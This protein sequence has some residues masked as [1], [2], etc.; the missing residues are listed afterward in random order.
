MQATLLRGVFPMLPTPFY[1]DGA[2]ALDDV[3]RLVDFAL[4]QGSAGVAALGLGGEA[5]FL[6]PEERKEVAREVLRAVAGR[7][8]VIVGCTAEDTATACALAAHAAGHGAAVVMV[9]PPNRAGISS[10]E[11]EAHY[12]QVALAAQPAALMVQDAPSFLAVELGPALA[13]RLAE[14]NDNVRYVKTEAVPAGVK[15]SAMVEA[16]QGRLA[17]FGGHGGLHLL[18]ELDAGAIGTIPGTEVVDACVA[19]V[20]AHQAGRRAEAE[21]R[22]RQ[23]LP[24]LVYTFQSLPFFLACAKEVLRRR[25][26]LRATGLRIP[27]ATLDGRALRGLERHARLAGYSW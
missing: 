2:L 21:E 27:G 3:P 10:A 5:S 9:A 6:T 7:A 1:G 22:Y 19:I 14:R 26:A 11:L 12:S 17:V 8:P 24:L 20:A 4:A 18:E 13:L 15:V 16:L 25:G 23:V